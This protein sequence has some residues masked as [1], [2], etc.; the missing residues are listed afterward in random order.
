MDPSFLEPGFDPKNLTV[1]Q[2]RGI[3]IDNNVHL[4]S[5]VKKAKLIRLFNSEIV[6]RLDELRDKYKNVKPSSKG[7]KKITTAKKSNKAILEH[8]NLKDSSES[9]GRN[10]KKEEKRPSGRGEE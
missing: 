3:L 10:K 7:I 9:S 2:L 8:Q 5:K 1:A 4:P 6:P